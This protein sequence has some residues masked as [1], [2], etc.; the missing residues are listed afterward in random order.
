MGNLISSAP[1]PST[2][3][4]HTRDSA[5]DEGL[6]DLGLLLSQIYRHR[7]KETVES[8]N[9]AL[10]DY[11]TAHD[12]KMAKSKSSD[13]A[14]TSEQDG[15]EDEENR[16]LHL[17]KNKATHLQ[18]LHHACMIRSLYDE[19][20]G[21]TDRNF[22]SLQDDAVE[23]KE[24]IFET[25]CFPSVHR[26][27]RV[28]ILNSVSSDR[29]VRDDDELTLDQAIECIRANARE[30]R[31]AQE[32]D[33]LAKQI[34]SIP[35]SKAINLFGKYMSLTS[36]FNAN[37]STESNPDGGSL[38][39]S[40]S[41]CR[42]EVEAL[43]ECMAKYH[44]RDEDLTA[45]ATAPEGSYFRERVERTWD[46]N[47]YLAWRRA[48]ACQRSVVSAGSI[49]QC[50]HEHLGSTPGAVESDKWQYRVTTPAFSRCLTN[51]ERVL[52]SAMNTKS[53]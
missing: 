23:R 29:R 44:M 14:D 47:C 3:V 22:V 2:T 28:A 13:A 50:L 18:L 7:C 32:M 46:S 53:L 20:E 10:D 36:Y 24:R 11:H 27:N 52:Q 48:Q 4:H 43:R 45:S 9:R 19:D 25:S 1:E 41:A 38:G 30:E 31:S 8:M 37:R 16:I 15:E 34:D 51:D 35:D 49:T 6:A 33:K 26:M 17:L 12:R 39:E 42:E 21:G 5:E 40:V